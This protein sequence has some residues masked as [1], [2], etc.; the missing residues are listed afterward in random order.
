MTMF[1][2]MTAITLAMALCAGT[3]IAQEAGKPDDKTQPKH[4][5]PRKDQPKK[6]QPKKEITLKVG[7]KAPALTVENWVKGDEVKTLE[8]GK[9]Y[10]VEFWATWCGPCIKSIPH[11]TELQ[12]EYK[13]KGVTV[14]GVTT[15]E[16]MNRQIKA[17]DRLQHVKDFV[18]EQGSKMEYTV[19]YDHDRS[20]SKDWLQAAGQGGIPCAFVVNKEGKITFIGNPLS[21]GTE[22]ENAIKK[23]IGSGKADLGRPTITLVSQPEK[24]KQPEK[25]D[26]TDGA[27]KGAS[28]KVQAGTFKSELPTLMLGDK[29]P[30]LTVSK[31]VKGEP[32][33]GFEKGKTYVVEFWA[34]WCGPCKVSIP[35]LTELQKDNPD[36]RFIGVSVWE[37]DQSKVEPFV[38]DMGDKMD[39]TVAMDD[40]PAAGEGS[41]KHE[42]GKMDKGWMGASGSNGIPTAFIVNGEGKIAWIGHPSELEEPLAKVKKGE[43]D[44]A[45]EAKKYR[46]AK[47]NEAKVKPMQDQLTQA[48]KTQDWDS[49][50]KALDAL[51]EADPNTATQYA[52]MKFNVLLTQAKDYDRAYAFASQAADGVLKD[53]SQALNS[54]AWTIVDPDTSD[55]I[56]KKDLKVALKLARRAD[57]VAKHQDAAILDT[58]ARVY[59]VS[60]DI[61]KALETQKKAIDA[62]PTTKNWPEDQRDQLRDELE[63]RLEEYK[64]KAGKGGH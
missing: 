37:S 13:N 25:A 64:E 24:D 1:R 34:T 22:L 12:K 38:K 56:E 6:D 7:D 40:V 49:A 16:D 20:M 51:M 5:Q 61:D 48:F 33:T 27:K 32:V 3:A 44:L 58:L 36:V 31:W 41:K 15:S 23:A 14:L 39:Y 29:A 21:D 60:G 9:V 62:I 17:D 19:G 2:R 57:E 10:V 50:V 45:A 55:E 8:A 54:F 52:M 11:L 26:K 4:E 35:H 42:K 18:K 59:F 53:N 46:T 43:W 47:E 30:E 63:S 28:D